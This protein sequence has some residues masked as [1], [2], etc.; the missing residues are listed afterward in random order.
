MPATTITP[1]LDFAGRCDEA[2]A[3][4]CE[5]LGA[6]VEMLM[7]FNESP[8][9]VPPGML[10][11]GF[12]KKVMH[13]SLRIRGIPLMCCDG[14]DDKTKFGGVRLALQVPAE[15]DARKAF[16][17]LAP[18]GTVQMPLTKTFW[19]PCFGMLTDKFGLGWMVMVPGP[20]G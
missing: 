3:F 1:Y 15:A 5:A 11:P 18:G 4:Y 2:I 12:E 19:S 20:M 13:A 16:D 8:E 9:P 14:C 7:R 10:Q 6:E 17:A